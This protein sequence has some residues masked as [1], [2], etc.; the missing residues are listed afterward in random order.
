MKEGRV[1]QEN[2]CEVRTRENGVLWARI[3]LTPQQVNARWENRTCKR[4]GDTQV[5]LLM[6]RRKIEEGVI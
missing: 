1:F 3:G 2:Q 5:E 4:S 6:M